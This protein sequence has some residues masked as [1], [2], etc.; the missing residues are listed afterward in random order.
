VA[1]P[2]KADIWWVP[3]TH[4]VVPLRLC[5]DTALSLLFARQGKLVK[6]STGNGNIIE[7]PTLN[8]MGL[9]ALAGDI[10][11]RHS[12]LINMLNTAVLSRP[13]DLCG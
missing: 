1:W 7:Q 10:L 9:R 4:A 2:S 11:E 5:L 6:G 3:D 12:S 13:C 8:R